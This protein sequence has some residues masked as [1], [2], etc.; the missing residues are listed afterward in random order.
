[1][2]TWERS[3]SPADLASLL[4]GAAD[5]DVGPVIDADDPMLLAP[6]D[7]P[8]RIVQL[9][10]RTDQRPP[11]SRPAL[12]RCILA[13]LGAAHAR[14]LQ[15]AIRLSG[16]SVRVVHLVGGGS[17]NELLCQLTADACGLPVVAGP[18]E[19]TAIGNALI[20]ARAHGLIDGT[21]ESLRGL[22]GDTQR[23]RRYEPHESWRAPS[24]GGAGAA[25]HR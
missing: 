8:A 16:R 18:A 25:E 3:G 7:I 6:G 5:L 19:A 21:L 12:V 17:Q 22:V 14:A 23:V 11:A 9:C 2:R 1:M 20:Q 24:K 4:A 15:D 10:E 13:S